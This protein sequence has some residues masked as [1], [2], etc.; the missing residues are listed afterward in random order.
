MPTPQRPQLGK[1]LA[2]AGDGRASLYFY[3]S[4]GASMFSEGTTAK[5]IVAALEEAEKAGAKALDIF[6]NSPGGSVF[7]GMAIYSCLKRFSGEK[8]VYVDGWAASIASIIAMAGDR[9]C[10]GTGAMMMVHEASGIAMGK[11]GEMRSVADRLD[12]IGESMLATYAER[13]KADPDEIRTMMK[14]ET[15]MTAAEAVER[16]FADDIFEQPPDQDTAAFLKSP[17]FASFHNVPESIRARAAVPPL[18]EPPAP[19]PKE[20]QMFKALLAKLGLSDAATEAQA[21]AAFETITGTSRKLI[22]VTGA[23]SEAE[24]LGTVTA[25]QASHAKVEELTAKVV[26]IEADAAKAEVKALLDGA[27]KDGKVAPAQRGALEALSPESL[28]AFITA[29]PAIHKTT[30]EA[31]KAEL[32]AEALTP[33]EVEVCRKQNIDPKKFLESKKKAIAEGRAP[34]AG[35]LNLLAAAPA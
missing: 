13:T 14:A 32:N 6:I 19:S 15:W 31:P 11:A 12:K 3:D 26:K 22:E 10:M 21:L 4:I 18:P 34:S 20:N 33:E 30:T 9:I 24:A 5:Q 25:W 17:I 29:A 35:I 7:E 8:V 28:K 2:R 1:F 16:K 27:I 23:K